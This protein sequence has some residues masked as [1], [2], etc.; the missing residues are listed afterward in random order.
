M[1]FTK[2]YILLPILVIF[3]ACKS[4]I[5]VPSK[6]ED[7]NFNPHRPGILL[8]LE[9]NNHFVMKIYPNYEKEMGKWDTKND[10]LFLNSEYKSSLES[11]KDS[12]VYSKKRIL[13]IKGKKL[14]YP[15]NQNFHLKRK[16]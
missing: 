16:K 4:K 13:L 8:Y 11:E 12:A 1:N 7:S 2:A 5:S 6:Y 15:E 14:I 10:S 3:T 9:K